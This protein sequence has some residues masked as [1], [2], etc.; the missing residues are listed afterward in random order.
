[1]TTTK[2]R[3]QKLALTGGPGGGKTKL[4]KFIVKKATA[5]GYHVLVVPEAATELMN[6]GLSPHGSRTNLL[7]FQRAVLKKTLFCEQV[8]EQELLASGLQKLLLVCDRGMPDIGAYV[9]DEDARLLLQEYGFAHPALARDSCYDAVLHMRTAALGADQHYSNKS[10]KQRSEDLEGAR[11]LDQRTMNAWLGHEH[12]AV[13]GNTY[14]SFRGKLEAGWRAARRLLGIPVPLEI[15]KKFL[16]EPLNFSALGIP[17]AVIDVEQYYLLLPEG[18]GK[19]CRVRSWGEG[20]VATYTLT[21]KREIAPDV[22]EEREERIS[23]MVFAHYTK[24]QKSGTVPIQ[25]RRTCFVYNDQYFMY[26]EFLT[27]RPGLTMLE[28]EVESPKSVVDLPPFVAVREDVSRNREYFNS[29]I[30]RIS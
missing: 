30:A 21:Q 16:V 15:E 23:E 20:G 11:A 5:I 1:M 10:N 3:V 13:V 22:R 29:T 7:N 24:Y 26:D 17:N 27:G 12:L 9:S 28:I 2:P 18:G 8:R 19:E 4:Q 25:K 6:V 14:G